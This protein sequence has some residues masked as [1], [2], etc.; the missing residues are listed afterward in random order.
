MKKQ[1]FT[2]IF[3][4]IVL[5]SFDSVFS[6]ET[7]DS[8]GTTS[9]EGTPRRVRRVIVAGRKPTMKIEGFKTLQFPDGVNPADVEGFERSYVP[10]RSTQAVP[11]HPATVV[12]Q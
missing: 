4:S 9:S 11:Q 10:P 8:V 1:Y 7:D 2:A 6:M 12:A 3:A 5:L